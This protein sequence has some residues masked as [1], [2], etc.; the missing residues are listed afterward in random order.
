MTSLYDH[1]TLYLADATQTG[2]YFEWQLNSNYFTNKRSRVC[3]VSCPMVAV[4]GLANVT[5]PL[6]VCYNAPV[7]NDWNTQNNGYHVLNVLQY[8]TNATGSFVI[9][10]SQ[11]DMIQ[12]VTNA[13][14]NVIR[15]S[16][17]DTSGNSIDA[18]DLGNIEGM[19]VLKYH[20]YDA[21]QVSRAVGKTFDDG[22]K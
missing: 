22:L 4:S 5:T 18:T 11:T 12:F 9:N 6:S 1:L 14:P 2:E 10:Q 15:I 21:Q 7:V 3:F 19:L 8:G 13:R 20:Y 17:R 16:F